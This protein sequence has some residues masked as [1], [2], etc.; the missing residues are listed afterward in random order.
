MCR[1]DSLRKG[2]GQGRINKPLS[3]KDVSDTD[4]G[5]R[6]VIKN[7]F[8]IGAW[9]SE[10][11]SEGNMLKAESTKLKVEHDTVYVEKRDSTSVSRFRFATPL[12]FRFGPSS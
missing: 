10:E 8:S 6:N 12:T 5:N 3:S 1:Y 9:G 2:K 11:S 7:L 4:F